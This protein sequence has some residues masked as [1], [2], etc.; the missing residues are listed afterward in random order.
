MFFAN[1]HKAHI[2]QLK[3]KIAQL[4]IENASL[5]Q[6]NKAY[7]NEKN[8]SEPVA[9]EA[10]G[11]EL[12]SMFEVWM[13]GGQLISKVRETVSQ[14]AINLEQEKNE[15]AESSGIFAQTRESV[16]GILER[17]ITIK[18][19][20]KVSNEQVK[21]LLT[22][23][24]Q[25]EEFVNVIQGISDQ[26]GLLALNAAIE[27]ARAGESGRGFAV[28][29]D[30]VRKLATNA[31]EASNEIATLVETISKQVTIVSEDIEQVDVLSSEVVD[32]T[33][34]VQDGVSELVDISA[35][36]NKVI[37]RSANDTFIETVKLDHVN[38]KNT[39]YEKILHHDFDNL[40]GMS[41]HK[42]CRLG[43]WYFE[44]GG[45]QRYSQFQG[46]LALDAPHAMVHRSGCEAALAM[47]QQDEDKAV[48]HLQK[49]EQASLEVADRLDEISN[50]FKQSLK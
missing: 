33:Q 28:V 42:A 39:I 40:D 44:G 32:A 37:T 18:D 5:I 21:S 19:R 13:R 1:Q 35:H 15:L 22:V 3:H 27:A 43:K 50:S 49:M 2:K 46:F 34:S 9:T 7:Q 41:E 25:I 30:E 47:Q 17:V 26:T 29:A 36:M 8:S 45:K 20:S 4:E 38:W 10:Q 6:E 23:S 12:K 14:T 48:T 16:A 11:V 24:K 31:N